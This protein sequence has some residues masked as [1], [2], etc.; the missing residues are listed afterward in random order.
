MRLR[1][2]GAQLQAQAPARRRGGRVAVDS[3]PGRGA[4][5]GRHERGVA[6][7]GDRREVPGRGRGRQQGPGRLRRMRIRARCRPGAQWE[8]VSK[9]A[10]LFMQGAH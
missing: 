6:G 9:N 10:C 4:R 2:A 7:I 3:R 1:G 5:V 8:S